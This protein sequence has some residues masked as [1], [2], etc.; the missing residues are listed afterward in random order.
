MK[1]KYDEV[2]RNLIRTYLKKC[3]IVLDLGC[4][5]DKIRLDAIGFDNG[6]H[7]DEKDLEKVDYILNLQDVEKLQ[8]CDGVC[9][10]HFLEHIV[11]VRKL[12]SVCYNALEKN[13][14]IAITVPDGEDVVASTLGDSTNTHEMLFTPTTIKLYLENAGFR[15]VKS[16]YYDRPYAYKQTKG[17]FACGEK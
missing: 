1:R 8:K 12:L 9:M 16:Q 5:V 13:G 10:S 14:R 4:N 15:N 11:D 7:M 6:L 17:I 3:K 2:G